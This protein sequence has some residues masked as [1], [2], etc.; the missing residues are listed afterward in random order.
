MLLG[1][2]HPGGLVPVI[3]CTHFISKWHVKG[4]NVEKSAQVPLIEDI[5]TKTRRMIISL[6]PASD[7]N[8][9]AVARTMR[10]IGRIGRYYGQSSRLLEDDWDENRSR[11]E[12]CSCAHISSRKFVHQS[13]EL[14]QSSC[15]NLE[16]RTRFGR[17]LTFPRYTITF[18]FQPADFAFD[19]P[20]CVLDRS[21]NSYWRP[22]SA[23]ASV[24]TSFQ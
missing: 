2:R 1:V 3:V 21:T 16:C 11:R 15:L 23:G 9:F 4:S 10:A 18:S 13:G 5:C 7:P 22:D 8:A 19:E 17:S 14:H 20:F 6:G 12:C 24:A